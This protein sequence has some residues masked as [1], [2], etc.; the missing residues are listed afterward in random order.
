MAITDMPERFTLGEV[1]V[2]LEVRRVRFMHQSRMKDEI[3]NI[4]FDPRGGMGQK[5]QL[6]RLEEIVIYSGTKSLRL[7]GPHKDPDYDGKWRT[8]NMGNGTNPYSE[9]PDYDDDEYAERLIPELVGRIIKHNRFIAQ[10]DN[11]GRL[12]SSYVPEEEQAEEDPTESET[13]LPEAD[14]SSSAPS[15]ISESPQ[16][17]QTVT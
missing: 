7:K 12:F 2:A 14:S 9:L 3:S 17:P 4:I 16:Q 6:G 11:F 8:V 13:N 10:D 5:L 1:E 15:S